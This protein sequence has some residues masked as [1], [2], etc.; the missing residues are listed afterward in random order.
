MKK[1]T[2]EQFPRMSGVLDFVIVSQ[3]FQQC[4]S[5]THI[6]LDNEC[7]TSYHMALIVNIDTKH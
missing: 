5:Y 3:R 6:F 2:P 1:I 4:V 7:I